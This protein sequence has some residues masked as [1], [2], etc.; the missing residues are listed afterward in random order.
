MVNKSSYGVTNVLI[1]INHSFIKN[2]RFVYGNINQENAIELANKLKENLSK[3]E[4]TLVDSTP[5]TVW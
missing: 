3:S 4:G 2:F 1:Q 5:Q